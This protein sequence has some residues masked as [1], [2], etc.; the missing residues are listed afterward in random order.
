MNERAGFT[1]L[2][3][4]N[5]W[6]KEPE[7]T[8]EARQKQ[9]KTKNGLDRNLLGIWDAGEDDYI[10]PP[11][12][13]LLGNIFCRQ[14]LSGLLADGGVGKTA[15]R[16]AQLLSLASGQSLTEEHVFVRCRVLFLSLEDSRDELRR[17]VYAALRYYNI[18]PADM[19]GWLFL[20]APKGIRLAEMKDG[21]PEVGPLKEYLEDAIK[22][23]KLD[24]IALD[25]FVK[26]HGVGEN[27]NNAIDF[28]CDLLAT[29]AIEQ[30]IA[31]DSPHHT[32]KAFGATPGD[33]NR[34]RGA[35]AHKDAGR[36][37]Y[38][39]TPCSPEE[40]GQMGITDAALRRSLIR[41]DSAKVNLMPPSTKAKWFQLVSVPLDN[42]TARYPGG[43][44]I[45]VAKPWSP[46]S[47]WHGLDHPL[48]NIILDDIDAGMKNGQRYSSA[49]AATDRAAWRVIQ[50]HSPEKTE[51]QCRIIIAAWVESGTLTEGE[52]YDPVDRKTRK[53]LAVNAAKRPS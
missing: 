1:G 22:T 20:A 44:H 39:L 26:T 2:E 9:S 30:D 6:I 52:S 21:A 3:R 11:R 14:F 41:M 19:R 27:D 4:P 15:V 48:L 29:I 13:W 42:A 49:S 51:K 31:C 17:R 40:A 37:V 8:E 47:A 35:T 5:D 25:P 24:M 45:Q 33:A 50:Q 34:G 16:L 28:V 12:G 36:L 38:T 53:G 10:I 46:P 7:G 32:N 23:L 18:E 43:D